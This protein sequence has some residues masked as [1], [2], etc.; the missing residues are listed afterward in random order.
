MEL[1]IWTSST[2]V[3]AT[4]GEDSKWNVTIQ[5]GDG[6]KRV[7][8]VNHLVAATGFAATS[9]GTIKLPE[10]PG[11]VRPAVLQVNCLRN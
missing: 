9:T 10:Y 4:P 11:M 5:R 3:N 2:V 7:L 1:N 8:R 6:A